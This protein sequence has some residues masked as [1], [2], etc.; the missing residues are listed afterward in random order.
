MRY[1]E[2]VRD[3]DIVIGCGPVLLTQIE[4]IDDALNPEG[5]LQFTD[6]ANTAAYEHVLSCRHRR[7]LMALAES[8]SGLPA[9]GPAT[10]TIA[11]RA[12]ELEVWCGVEPGAGYEV[13]NGRLSVIKPQ[14]PLKA[15]DVQRVGRLMR[16]MHAA[17]MDHDGLIAGIIGGT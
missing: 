17:R 15:G 3:Y 13:L 14:F 4:C 9:V 12:R 5:N 7:H 6:S 8:K 1:E 11:Q 2:A 10:K 16:A